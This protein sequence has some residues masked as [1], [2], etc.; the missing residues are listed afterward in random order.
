[1]PAE[2]LIGYCHRFLCLRH[3]DSFILLV[4]LGLQMAAI[5][6]FLIKHEV[7]SVNPYLWFIGDALVIL[8][9]I[10]AIV[11]SFRFVLERLNLQ[12]AH[13]DIPAIRVPIYGVLPCAYISWFLYASLLIAKICVIFK[14][15]IPNEL[16]LKGLLSTTTLKIVLSMTVVVFI[17]LI[18]TQHDAE[19]NSERNN[20]IADLCKGTAFDLF[21]S[22]QFLGYLFTKESKL[23]QYPDLYSEHLANTILALSCL[24]FILPGVALYKLSLSEF[25]E[26][27]SS[28][29]LSLIIKSLKLFAINL[30][31]MVIR[32]YLWPI[33]DHVVLFLIKNV[34]YVAIC[35][36]YMIPEY[37]NACRTFSSGS[38]S[39]VVKPLELNTIT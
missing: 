31:Y 16:E 1:M 24:N 14:S 22:I 20:Y 23:T 15:N 3:L 12:L 25:G 26:L 34:L 7:D 33:D 6:Y 9:F 10:I 38:N 32:I 11:I 19:P 35:L 29:S 13:L 2:R 21:D 4:G 5:N 27:K 28:L 18:N 36:R 37:I 8:S 39:S 17:L 30:P